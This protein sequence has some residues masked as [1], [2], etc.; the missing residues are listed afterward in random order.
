MSKPFATDFTPYC[1]NRSLLSTSSN[2]ASNIIYRLKL[3]LL[4]TQM[5]KC[6]GLLLQFLSIKKK[7]TIVFFRTNT[8]GCCQPT[9]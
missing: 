1:K 6:T 8:V 2:V 5:V 7:L 9:G 4:T 3:F